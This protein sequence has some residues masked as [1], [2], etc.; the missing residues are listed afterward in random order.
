[1]DCRPNLRASRHMLV[2]WLGFDTVVEQVWARVLIITFTGN[3]NKHSVSRLFTMQFLI[4]FSDLMNS[5]FE[6]GIISGELRC[7][8]MR[9]ETG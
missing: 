5:V 6:S 8:V 9:T 1:M 2:T 3:K 7:D 4:A